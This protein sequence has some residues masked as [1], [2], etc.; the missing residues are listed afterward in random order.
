MDTHPVDLHWVISVR[1]AHCRV[2]LEHNIAHQKSLYRSFFFLYQSLIHIPKIPTKNPLSNSFY[3]FQMF[4]FSVVVYFEDEALANLHR[5]AR[6]FLLCPHNGSGSSSSSSSSTTEMLCYSSF[7]AHTKNKYKI[8]TGHITIVVFFFFFFMFCCAV[9]CM[10]HARRAV[11]VDSQ[12]KDAQARRQ[13]YTHTYA[14]K[15]SSSNGMPRWQA[16]RLACSWQAHTECTHVFL[17]RTEEHDGA[18]VL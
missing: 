13:P 15:L 3:C 7:N 4:F 1:L 2:P 6:A 18:A 11:A 17:I 9:F 16:A 12:A 5:R 14:Q 10:V 8:Q